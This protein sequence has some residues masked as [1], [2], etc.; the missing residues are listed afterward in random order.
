MISRSLV[1]AP[2]LAMS[3][4]V[5]EEPLTLSWWQ[6]HHQV[7]VVILG[8]ILFVAGLLSVWQYASGRWIDV[9][10]VSRP[11]EIAAQF[12]DWCADGTLLQHAQITIIEVVAGF[13]LGA[14]AGAVAAFA[15]AP[16]RLVQR[17][18]DPFI[19]ALYSLPKVALA[20]LFI[21]WFGIG[22]QMK[23]L[24]ALIT[25]F[26]LVFLN[27][28]SGIRQVDKAL[29]DA[30]RLMG[31]TRLQLIRK[32]VLPASLAGLFTGLK[33]AIP[34]ALIGAVIGELVASNRGIGYLVS[35]SASRFN[36]AG[37]FAALAVLTLLAWLLNAVVS[38]FDRAAS[39]WKG[40]EF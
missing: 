40:S 35:D 12:V 38:F 27:T 7:V 6:R 20:P 32:V 1:K 22:I 11:S 8:R 37:V 4:L 36:T 3:E 10:L 18:V 28:L 2:D 21:V 30:V 19:Y 9:L 26:F 39:R 31:C 13:V 23:I 5:L 17:V 34:Y 24:L 25:V 16:L 15:L 14:A 33:V 29:I